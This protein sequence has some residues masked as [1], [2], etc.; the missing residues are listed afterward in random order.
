MKIE[1]SFRVSSPLDETWPVLLDIERVAPA[2]P[3]AELQEVDG[4][5]YSGVVKVKVGPITAQYK[6]TATLAE[7]D[8]GL[9]T[10][11]IDAAGR[12]SR[13]QGNAKAKISVAMTADGADATIV[14]ID[15]DLQITG[16]VAQFARGGVLKEVSEKLLHQFA[17]N[18]ERDI[19]GAA[20]AAESGDGEGPATPG[21]EPST[22]GVPLQAA[23][24]PAGP[25]RIESAPVEPVDLLEVAGAPVAKRVAP[26]AL[27]ALILLVLWLVFRRRD[28]NR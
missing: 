6:G 5:D 2:L 16:K 22:P 8:H 10:L 23:S 21:D 25:R 3:G 14:A 9:H 7:V 13:G 18:L 11:L 12:D 20:G 19:L 4:D 28:P 17:E 27:G 15:T 26:I 1:D 24:S